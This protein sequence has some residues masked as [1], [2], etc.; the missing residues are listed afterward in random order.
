MHHHQ[1]FVPKE[2]LSLNVIKQYN[3][4]WVTPGVAAAPW[5]KPGAHA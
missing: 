5:P 1:V 2:N 3:V 4:M